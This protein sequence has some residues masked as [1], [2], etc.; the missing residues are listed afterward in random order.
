M[1]SLKQMEDRFNYWAKYDYVF[2]NDNDFSEEFQTL[3]Q[4]VIGTKAHYGKIE[5]DVWHQPSW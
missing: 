5:Y 3:T 4:N 2:L 1:Q